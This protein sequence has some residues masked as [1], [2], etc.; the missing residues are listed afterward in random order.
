MKDRAR[1]SGYW[2]VLG[3]AAGLMGLW[4]VLTNGELSS[5]LIGIPTVILATSMS[6][7]LTPLQGGRP[8]LQGLLR[9]I[10][11]FLWESLRG[12]IDVAARV[13]RP[14]M[15]LQAGLRPYML[16]LSSPASRVLFVDF[17]SLLPGTLSAE[18]NGTEVLVHM[19]DETAEVEKELGRLEQ[20]VR[21][22]LREDGGA[23]Q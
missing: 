19:I 11:F 12:G 13:I 22:L 6:L 2:S 10:P 1:R 21:E 4:V 16:R 7:R 17:V 9:F 20:R 23:N 14:R 15:R 18:V 5:W 3:R 8:R